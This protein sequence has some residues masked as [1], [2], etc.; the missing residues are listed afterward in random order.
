MR[1][2][3]ESDADVTEEGSFG[4]VVMTTSLLRAVAWQPQRGR[5]ERVSHPQHVLTSTSHLE[6]WVARLKDVIEVRLILC[7]YALP[8]YGASR[9]AEVSMEVRSMSRKFVY[10]S[11]KE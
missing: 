8:Q 2:S 6:W 4:V 11:L 9:S 7:P 10:A 3:V 5:K 1:V